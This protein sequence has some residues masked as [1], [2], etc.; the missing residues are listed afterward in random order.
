MMG[1]IIHGIIL[2]VNARLSSRF[3]LTRSHEVLDGLH[4]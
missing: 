4:G 2:K 1:D 3:A